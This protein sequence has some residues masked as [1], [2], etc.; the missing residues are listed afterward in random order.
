MYFSFQCFITT[1]AKYGVMTFTCAFRCLILWGNLNTGSFMSSLLLNHTPAD[2]PASWSCPASSACY[3]TCPSPWAPQL[4]KRAKCLPP[5]AGEKRSYITNSW[6]PSYVSSSFTTMSGSP[7]NIYAVCSWPHARATST[8]PES[9]LLF[10]PPL[11][12]YLINPNRP[13]S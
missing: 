12:R 6:Y 10:L 3:S 2:K 7:P 8:T 4:Q 1:E 11:L 9:I 5:S 13:C